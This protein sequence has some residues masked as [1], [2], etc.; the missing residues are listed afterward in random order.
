MCNQTGDGSP[1]R[2]IRAEHLGKKDPQSD[3]R[4]IDSIHPIHF[5]RRQG[6]CYHRLGKHVA[7]RQTSVLK[8]LPPQEA[9]LLPKPTRVRISH[10]GASLPVMDVVTNTI[11]AG[12]ALF[13]YVN[14]CQQLARNLRAIRHIARLGK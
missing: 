14:L 10:P 13:A 2:L 12:E 11:Y 3:Q 5:D 6:T 7:E 9:H 1:A 8:K 4:R